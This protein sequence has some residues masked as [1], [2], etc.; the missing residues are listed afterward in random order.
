MA[1]MN[2]EEVLTIMQMGHNCFI[3][4][5]AGTG[6]SYVINRYVKYLRANG[7]MQIALTAT[8]GVAA[9]HINGITIHAWSGLYLDRAITK[10]TW[11][12]IRERK[13]IIERITSTKVLIIDEISMMHSYQLDMI[14]HVCRKARGVNRPFG[15]IQV[16]MS[17]D[18]FQLTPVQGPDDPPAE[19]VVKSRAWSNMDPKI[20]Y[21]TEQF[22]QDDDRLLK[23]LNEIRTGRVSAHSRSLLK[24]RLNQQ[25]G[26][27][28]NASHAQ[29]HAINRSA[30]AINEDKLGRLKQ[31][32]VVYEMI[33]KGSPEAV[34]QL[35]NDCTASE[36]VCLKI[37]AMIMFTRNNFK[38]GYVNGAIGQVLAFDKLTGYPIVKTAAKKKIIVGRETWTIENGGMPMAEITQIPL[39]LAWAITVHKSQ[40]MSL[41]TAVIDLRQAFVESMG[42]VALSRV[43]RLDGISL[44]GIS[45]RAL[46]VCPESIKLDRDL[47]EQAR[48]LSEQLRHSGKPSAYYVRKNT[49]KLMK[50]HETLL[51]I[52]V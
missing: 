12:R 14:D 3:T 50:R 38:K 20:C 47:Q 29:L 1:A 8:T 28:T 40:G 27:I 4:G 45:R 26:P 7:I 52:P 51:P 22:R 34:K 44:L 2:Q 43:R 16:I 39:R 36:K 48:I 33:S 42:Y 5:P 49:L 24:T 11:K 17:G 15:G 13:E 25:L 6:K 32:L 19:F 23:I 30:N 9:A 37:G 21:L 31:D 10:K 41:D 46:K 18:F 35:K